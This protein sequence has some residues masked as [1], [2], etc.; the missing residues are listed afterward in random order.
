MSRKGPTT[1]D[2]SKPAWWVLAALC[3]LVFVWKVGRGFPGNLW[4]F[5]VY[6][7]SAQAWAHGV[8]PYVLGNLPQALDQGYFAFT[9]PPY[10]LPIFWPFTWLS[11][12]SAAL[13]FLTIKL[14][15]LAWLVVVWSRVLRISVVTPSWLLFLVFA[16]SSTIFV[17]VASGNIVVFEQL[18]VWTGLWWLVR[19]RYAAFVTAIVA[20]SLFKFTPIVLLA[21]CLWIPDRRRYWYGAAGLAALGAIV[22][23]TYVISPGLTGDF[24]RHVSSLDERGA[25]NAALLSLMRDATDL[26]ARSYGLALGPGAGTLLYGLAAASVLGVTWRTAERVSAA[27]PDRRIEVILHLVVL[28][29]AVAAPRMKLY[30]YMLAVVPTYYV[31]TQATRV[32]P[33]VPLLVLA[34]LTTN[35]WMLRPEYT[36]LA[37]NYWSWFVVL[38]AWLILVYEHLTPPTPSPSS[39]DA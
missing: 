11:L 3:A 18:L 27:Q 24:F 38:G 2:S 23:T 6:Y 16:Y 10:I 20:A 25:N 17:D 33:A 19:G 9:Y 32:R 1:P 37:I 4:D 5:R 15:L 26:L 28:A 22:L 35:S 14:V 7:Y 30:A 13:V 36:T 12:P 39:G 34:C 21:L 8:N 31:A 29:C